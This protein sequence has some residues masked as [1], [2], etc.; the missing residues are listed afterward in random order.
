MTPLGPSL[1]APRTIQVR[2]AGGTMIVLRPLT[3]EDR[4]LLVAGFARLSPESRYRRFFSPVP[5]LTDS[6]LDRLADV[7]GVNHFA[8]V[9]L[10]REDGRE[11]AVGFSRYFRL[12]DSQ[13]AEMAV[14]VIDGYQG[15]GIGSLL[16]DALVRQAP[17][18]G[19]TRFEGLVLSDNQ[20]MV[21]LLRKAGAHLSVDEPGVHRFEIDL[22]THPIG[23]VA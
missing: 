17:E 12:R 13:A 3:P 1:G 9:A 18:K 2:L 6:L 5:R 10:A 11:V 23:A 4:G 20:P 14:S 22:S 21:K 8:W 15:R 7:D 16:V 19:I